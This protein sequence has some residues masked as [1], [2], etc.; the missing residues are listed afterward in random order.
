L[1]EPTPDPPQRLRFADLTLDIG[2]RRVWRGAEAIGLS[3]RTFDLLRVLAEA[4]PDVVSHD[5]LAARVWGPRRIVTPENLSQGILRLRQAVGDDATN[6]RYVES[7]RGQGYRLIPAVERLP[8]SLPKGQTLAIDAYAFPGRTVKYVATALFVAIAA[9]LVVD[10]Y[11]LRGSAGDR[12]VLTID[13]ASAMSRSPRARSESQR[14]ARSLA[15]LPCTNLSPNSED[16]YFATGI[17]NEIL[18][19]L[20]KVRTFDLRSRTSTL[21]YANTEIPIPE[22][23]EALGVGAIV[24]CSVSYADDRVRVTVQLVDAAKDQQLWA[25]SYERDFADIFAIQAHIATSIANALEAELSVGERERIEKTPTTS[26]EAYALYLRSLTIIDTG[27]AGTFAGAQTQRRAREYLDRAIDLDPLFALAHARKATMF[28]PL[29]MEFTLASA[30]TALSLDPSLGLAHAVRATALASHRRFNEASDSCEQAVT[31]DAR[32]AEVL[33]RCAVVYL[34]ARRPNDAVDLAD[35]AVA[36][37]GGDIARLHDAHMVY[38]IT[39]QAEKDEAV[40][41]RA[42]ELDPSSGNARADFGVLLVKHGN[43]A[44]GLDHLRIGERLLAEDQRASLWVAYGYHI[45]GLDGDAARAVDTWEALTPEYRGV[46]FSEIL[47]GLV[48][49][50]HDRVLREIVRSA[51]AGDWDLGLALIR[52]N[53]L[54]DPVLDRPEFVSARQR[55]GLARPKP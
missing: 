41:R 43:Q 32:N 13:P 50:D 42:V 46:T 18:T 8:L 29:E 14:S 36:V 40:V 21:H 6:P 47:A 34:L 39:G 25:E 35:E 49:G 53:S 22:I 37:D 5:T 38:F 44:E 30:E 20:A 10:T 15:V 1:N 23:A 26:L 55:L 54:N 7:L 27:Y 19:Q 51:D 48:V 17:H 45:A 52:M 28:N 11:V 33:S 4:A 24:E 16:A 9:F 3:K 12:A 2:Q 31:L